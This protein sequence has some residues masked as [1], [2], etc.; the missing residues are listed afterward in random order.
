MRSKNRLVVAAAAALTLLSSASALAH[1]SISET[2]FAGQTQVLT[3][4]VGHGCTGADTIGVEIQIP[5]EVTVVRGVPSFFGVADVKTDQAGVVTSVVWSKENARQADDQFYQLQ[6]RIKVP[7]VAFQ[8]LYFPTVQH[9]R[10]ADGTL[11]DSKWTATPT[12]MGEGLEEAPHLSVL[13]PRKAGWNKYTAPREITDLSI[14]DDAQI[15]WV[16]EAAY[17][18]NEATKALIAGEEGVTAL[19]KIDA[20][21][22]IWVKY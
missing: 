16:G 5:K 18:S 17:S 21:A 22:E 4:N 1:I 19:T 15:V 3:F 13:P 6:L 11:S 2:G 9:C 12:N 20:N 14:F 10:A 8:T 7:D